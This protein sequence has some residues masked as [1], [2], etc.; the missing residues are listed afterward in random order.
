MI[1]V[2][3]RA[4]AMSAFSLAVSAKIGYSS[5]NYF[6]W[7]QLPVFILIGWRAANNHGVLCSWVTY[8]WADD[9]VQVAKNEM[10]ASAL[11]A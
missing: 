3:N 11:L 5:Y 4:I 6:W 8:S 2:V 7:V 1:P 10:W 9:T